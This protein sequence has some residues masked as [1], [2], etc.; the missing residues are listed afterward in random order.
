M[1]ELQGRYFFHTQQFS[2]P[3]PAMAGNDLTIITNQDR[4]GKAECLNAFCNLSN[5]PPRMR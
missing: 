2:R 1:R 3:H 5:L 4:I